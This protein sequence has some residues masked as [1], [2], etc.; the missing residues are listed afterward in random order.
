MGKVRVNGVE[1][2][3][4]EAGSGD[5]LLLIMGFGGDHLAWAFQVPVFS[6]RYRVITFDNRGAG[7]SS[8]PDVPYTTRM[9]A[10]DAVGLLDALEIERAHVLGVSMGGMIAQELALRYP[11][12]CRSL[13]LEGTAA[14]VD[15]YVERFI[16]LWV[17]AR[18]H[19][20][21]EDFQWFLH[22]FN[23]HPRNVASHHLQLT[24]EARRPWPHPQPLDALRWQADALLAFDARDRL[25]GLRVPTL[26]LVGDGDLQL[27]LH[28]S[29]ELHRLI[30]GS[31]LVVVPTA[32]HAV[33]R[34][35]PDRWVAAAAPFLAR[36]D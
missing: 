20:P 30:P 7:Q 21:P 23:W 15:A 14:G 8:V 9:M 11:E 17:S 31:E 29:E 16:R 1:L 3:Y 10:D 19:L 18:M 32:G 27:P 12:R 22:L 36:Q 26:I 4:V 5:P 25:P 2:H 33:R 28:C 24:E 6:E 34:E 35:W 13:I